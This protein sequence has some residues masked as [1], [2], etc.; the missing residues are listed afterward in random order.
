MERLPLLAAVAA[1]AAVV[2]LLTRRSHFRYFADLK[3]MS[4]TS[5][6]ALS[7]PLN[8]LAVAGAAALVFALHIFLAAPPV[9]DA[10][11][12]RPA[13]HATQS[14]IRFMSGTAAALLLGT[15][16]TAAL[17]P[18][19]QLEPGLVLL[20]T[21]ASQLL[22]ANLALAAVRH[23]GPL[24]VR[25]TSFL[26]LLASV[27]AFLGFM[28]PAA[29]SALGEHATAARAGTIV[30]RAGEVAFLFVP[31]TL[32]F[33]TGRLAVR[34][35]KL[36]LT[37]A[38]LAGLAA[39]AFVVYGALTAGKDFGTILYGVL[40]LEAFS[41]LS[42]R[43]Y[44]IPMGVAAGLVALLAIGGTENARQRAA[45]VALYVAAGYAPLSPALLLAMTLGATLLCRAA[46]A[47]GP[48][49]VGYPEAPLAGPA[50]A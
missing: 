26:L 24:A 29:F 33:Q 37:A 6:A 5:R 36:A 20:A 2:D 17:K 11:R 8:V 7:L 49:G 14:F 42:P 35:R 18:F 10:R 50:E 47:E 44:A 19:A 21:A 9:A 12:D 48:T 41:G 25:A 16:V 23:P 3:A 31:A 46:I 45:G 27:G 4:S 34:R 22:V 30:R 1:L 39:S 38:F 32:A 43:A 28:L 40:R 13:V 15:V